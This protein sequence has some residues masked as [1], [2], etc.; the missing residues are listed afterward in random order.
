[1]KKILIYLF[2]AMFLS[3]PI[4][5]RAQVIGQE[6]GLEEMLFRQIAPVVAG[7]LTE[8]NIKRSPVSSTI[9]TSEMIEMTPVRNIYDLLEAYVPGLTYFT[10]FDSTHIGVRGFIVDRD[11]RSLLLLNGKLINQKATNGMTTELE[12]WD[13]NDIE[14]IEVIRG[15]GSVT[16][17]PGA[18][19]SVIN[20]IT[21]NATT[22]KGKKAGL[23]YVSGYNSYG[24]Y[25]SLGE[26]FENTQ[27]YIYASC[28]STNGID[29]RIYYL[30]PRI[31]GSGSW[32]G[33]DGIYSKYDP[34]SYYSDTENQ[35]QIKFHTQF[36]F[37]KEFSLYLRYTNSGTSRIR[38]W[39]EWPNNATDNLHVAKYSTA[40]E[41]VNGSETRNRQ[42]ILALEDN[43][44]FANDATLKSMISFDSMDGYRRQFDDTWVN[45]INNNGNPS[46]KYPSNMAWNYA[47]N[48]LE[49][50]STLNFDIF[51]KHNIALGGE[52]SYETYGPG[53]GQSAKDAVI[54]DGSVILC[55]PD[56]KYLDYTPFYTNV[57]FTE[58][59]GF[60]LY[61]YAFL[62]EAN[63]KLT[64]NLSVLLS[65]RLDKN[66]FSRY[67]LSPRVA[68]IWDMGKFGTSR[69]TMQE[70]IRMPT[71]V[72]LYLSG[73]AGNK[74][75]P[76]Q[77]K[78]IEL[79]YQK[80]ISNFDFSLTGFRNQLKA[81][82]WNSAEQKS[83]VSGKLRTWGLECEIAYKT[84]KNTIGL[85]YAYAK[86]INWEVGNVGSATAISTE[87][88]FQTYSLPDG[89]ILRSWG[90]NLLN[91]P[92]SML[93]L[94]A[95]SQ[96]NKK[97]K[98]LFDCQAFWDYAGEKEWMRMWENAAIGTASQQ[99]ILDNIQRLKDS[100]IYDVD[101][102]ANA[103][104]K[105]QFNDN[106]SMN[107]F[108]M[109]FLP[110]FNNYRYQHMQQ[111]VV[112]IKEPTVCGFRVD[113]KY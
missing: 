58:K 65:D 24:G 32:V 56:A 87:D 10:H 17:G 31:S 76:E 21:K 61:N 28:R 4:S 62:A 43:H 9:I 78:S 57:Y 36:D 27:A 70:S 113:V 40:G 77:L 38:S 98:L 54:F 86:Q 102:R 85:N 34:A 89:V 92:N 46:P 101:F 53:W 50:K 19:T 22:G 79:G 91:W 105:Y 11:Y 66:R 72:N 30:D 52:Y 59:Y 55:A 99:T 95:T 13:L 90:D 16:Y 20:I 12:N 96:L 94:F 64:D 48:K 37:L 1:M 42:F 103:A 100:G 25:A 111:T 106:L 8:K 44:I 71:A 83:E 49:M 110:I 26:T 109:N 112:A 82:S 47:E 15:P 107:I 88:Y 81:I 14:R 68:A 69:V 39:T 84:E 33:E 108:V 67:L 104:L 7:T 2:A 5:L 80:N 60:S 41:Y 93:K 97:I 51:D 73:R 63:L 3:F 74:A 18:I 6:I 23:A 75:D 29:P 35:P 45:I